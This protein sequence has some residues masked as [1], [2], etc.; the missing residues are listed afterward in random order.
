VKMMP[1]R[2]ISAIP[3]QAHPESELQQ[4][5]HINRSRVPDVSHTYRSQC[6]K[7][8][9]GPHKLRNSRLLSRLLLATE[10]ML[11]HLGGN[12]PY[13]ELLS[14]PSRTRTCDRPIMSRQL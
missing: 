11:F 6:G 2:N 13:A 1:K 5:S 7:Y 4:V 3:Q 8:V 10:P 12:P 14:G 9:P